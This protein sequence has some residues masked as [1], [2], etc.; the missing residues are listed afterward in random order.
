MINTAYNITC[1]I[2]FGITIGFISDR[3]II[4]NV[5]NAIDRLVLA[6]PEPNTREVRL[7]K[8]IKKVEAEL[9]PEEALAFERCRNTETALNG[10]TRKHVAYICD[11]SSENRGKLFRAIAII[12]VGAPVIEELI[13]RGALSYLFEDNLK[14][15]LFNSF[16]FGMVHYNTKWKWRTNFQVI[17]EV[18]LIGAIYSVTKIWGSLFASIAA[19]A[20]H[21][22]ECV[23]SEY[24]ASKAFEELTKYPQILKLLNKHKIQFAKVFQ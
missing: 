15:T 9:T 11:P 2:A 3:I 1:Q 21:N 6:P 14:Y 10:I 19:H 4:P 22:I 12:A 7:E 17:S 23:Y 16:L 5:T 13:F 8:R 24:K 20:V 18:M